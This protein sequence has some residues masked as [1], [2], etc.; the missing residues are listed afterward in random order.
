MNQFF[1]FS[2]F[3]C[4]LSTIHDIR[5]KLGGNAHPLFINIGSEDKFKGLMKNENIE[6]F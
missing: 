4:F 6:K 3:N 2:F 5:K 1:D